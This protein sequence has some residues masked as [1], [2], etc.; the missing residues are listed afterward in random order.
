MNKLWAVEVLSR[1]KWKPRVVCSLTK[2][3][4]EKELKFWQETYPSFSFRLVKYEA[5]I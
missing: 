2:K 3:S 1:G 5:V 4:G